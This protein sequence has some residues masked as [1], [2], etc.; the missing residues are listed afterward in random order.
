MLL[1]ID[2]FDC[3]SKLEWFIMV[4]GSRLLAGDSIAVFEGLEC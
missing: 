3:R 4:A 1:V 2:E